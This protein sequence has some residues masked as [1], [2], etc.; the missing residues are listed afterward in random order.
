M[1]A[2][3]IGATVSPQADCRPWRGAARLASHCPECGIECSEHLPALPRASDDT[4]F[5]VDDFVRAYDQGAEQRKVGRAMGCSKQRI[6]QIER[7]ARLKCAAICGVDITD[8]LDDPDAARAMVIAALAALKRL[9]QDRSSKALRHKH[10]SLARAAA[11]LAIKEK[12][13]DCHIGGNDGS[14]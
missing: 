1:I 4:L 9:K 7:F 13:A 12:L 2:F 11:N 10:A 8:T 14:T 6:E 5:T 3:M